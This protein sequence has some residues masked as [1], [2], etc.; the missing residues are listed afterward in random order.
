M[1]ELHAGNLI[2]VDSSPWEFWMFSFKHDI[3]FKQS[4]LFIVKQVIDS[5]S[6][7]FDVLFD[8]KIGKFDCAELNCFYELFSFQSHQ[9]VYC[10]D[11]WNIFVDEEYK[12]K[13]IA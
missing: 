4:T 9:T 3:Y 5:D 7:L 10:H 12:I 6:D 2:F 13:V 1:T 11:K 8:S